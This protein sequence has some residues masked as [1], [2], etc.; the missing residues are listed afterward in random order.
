MT[1]VR[2]W[3][4]T[5]YLRHHFGASPGFPLTWQ[6]ANPHLPVCLN[7]RVPFPYAVRALKTIYY[8]RTK[9]W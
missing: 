2:T 8:T 6:G 7:P 5:R 4:V 9:N 1:K 3:G